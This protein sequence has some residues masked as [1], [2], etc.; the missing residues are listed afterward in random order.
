MDIEI[1]AG[2]GGGD[3]FEMGEADAE[4]SV[5]QMKDKATSKKGRG[6]VDS[7]RS[8][9]P[10][11]GPGDRLEDGEGFASARVQPAKSV[12]GWIIFIN[13]LHEETSEENIMDAFQEY[14]VIKN[15]HLNQDRRT[16]FIKGYALVEYESFKEADEA[17]AR[18]HGKDLLGSTIQV[19]WAFV[20]GNRRA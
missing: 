12:E 5:E 11:V 10:G 4:R 9:R 14:G 8:T 15:L 20:K 17:V 13:N 1:H 6:F 19:T 3:D 18:M 2:E 16:G 7:S